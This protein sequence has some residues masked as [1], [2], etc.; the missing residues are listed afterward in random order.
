MMMSKIISF[1]I[2]SI[3]LD[4]RQK[5]LDFNNDCTCFRHENQ[6]FKNLFFYNVYFLKSHVQ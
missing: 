6:L 3:L 4:I 1:A 5:T 2:I